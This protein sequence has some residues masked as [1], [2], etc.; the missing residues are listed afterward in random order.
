MLY[1]E[2]KKTTEH[3]FC[4]C[5]KPNFRNVNDTKPIHTV[6]EVRFPTAPCGEQVTYLCE[7]CLAVI[8]EPL[9]DSLRSQLESARFVNSDA[10]KDALIK[11]QGERIK[12]LESEKE[13]VSKLYLEAHNERV[14]A[15]AQ[16]T[17][18]QRTARDAK[19][20]LC[21]KCGRYHEA[22]NGA[23]DGCRWKE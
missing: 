6:Y 17:T 23:C 15:L 12:T 13:A 2:I 7:D 14:D 5:G 4:T 19:N 22:H 16:L 3:H 18:A 9:I 1:P 21:L 10:A 20:E 8:A 11:A